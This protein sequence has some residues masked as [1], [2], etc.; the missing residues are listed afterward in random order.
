MILPNKLPRVNVAMTTFNHESYIENAL[1]SVIRQD[2]AGIN[3]IY[4]IDDASTDQ[5]H[6]VIEALCKEDDR[7]VFLRNTV[8][9]GVSYSANAVADQACSDRGVEY[10]ALFSGDDIWHETKIRKQIEFSQQNPKYDLIFTDSYTVGG[11]GA[12]TERLEFFDASNFSRREW[13]FKLFLRNSLL[14]PSVL[15]KSVVWRA[16]APFDISIRQIQD[17]QFWI[18]AVCRG[19]EI[20]IL[21][22]KLTFYRYLSTSVSNNEST[23]KEMRLLSE[24]PDCLMAFKNL[25]LGELRAVFG[26]DLETSEIFSKTRSKEVGLAVLGS[27]VKSRGH[28]RFAAQLI[29]D[30]FRSHVDDGLLTA[31]EVSDF[32]GKLDL[33]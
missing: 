8:N 26:N 19:F 9:S 31:R 27:L 30:Y 4:V 14:A 22:E 11:D 18:R 13:I 1:R 6:R 17:W 7:I 32:V 2:Y 28:Q 33:L 3:K 24:I 10:L 20:H 29:R 5:T 21:D 15:M 25:S 23:E 12:V 16:C